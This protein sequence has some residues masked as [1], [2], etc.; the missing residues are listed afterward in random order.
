MTDRENPWSLRKKR[1]CG[2]D[3]VRLSGREIV[4]HVTARNRFFA[5]PCLI[6]SYACFT[7]R[8]FDVSKIINDGIIAAPK[9]I[10]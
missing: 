1:K 2:N 4:G 6:I 7:T 9:V 10:K 5:L 3:G 8:D